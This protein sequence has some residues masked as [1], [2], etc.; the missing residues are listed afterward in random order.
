MAEPY[1]FP[2]VELTKN[3][4]QLAKKTMLDKL[5]S[6]FADV[7]NKAYLS[8]GLTEKDAFVD[9]YAVLKSGKKALT[10]AEV[11][12]STDA[13]GVNPRKAAARSARKKD[14]AAP[15]PEEGGPEAQTA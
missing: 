14:A 11:N 1:E 12:E 6:A 2:K 4:R 3:A 13:P 10:P 7:V 15:T 5:G 9:A 8:N